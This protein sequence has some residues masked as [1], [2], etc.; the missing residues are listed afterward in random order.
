MFAKRALISAMKATPESGFWVESIAPFRQTTKHS[1]HLYND[2][3]VEIRANKE[4]DLEF[5]LD[6]TVRPE[7][8]FVDNHIAFYRS[9]KH[10]SK[11]GPEAGD[12]PSP[13]KPFNYVENNTAFYRSRKY[14]RKQ[15]LDTFNSVTSPYRPYTTSN[16]KYEQF[17][18]TEC[19]HLPLRATIYKNYRFP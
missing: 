2:E 9:R 4:P 17:R 13:F 1:T 12:K 3:K 18:V 5:Y 7:R 15:G 6:R 16:M 14:S 11:Y 8:D 19:G 10:S